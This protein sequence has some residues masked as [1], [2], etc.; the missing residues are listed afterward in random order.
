MPKLQYYQ[1][2]RNHLFV[3]YDIILVIFIEVVA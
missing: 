2:F 1:A 3:V